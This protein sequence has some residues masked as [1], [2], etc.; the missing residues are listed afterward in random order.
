MI[1]ALN[2]KPKKNKKL[3]SLLVF[4]IFSFFPLLSQNLTYKLYWDSIN[5]LIETNY[6]TAKKKFLELKKEVQFDPTIELLFLEH[7]LRHDDIDFFK[8][9]IPDLI[10]NHGY[11]FYRVDTLRYLQNDF[12]DLVYDKGLS[13]W[14]LKSCDEL[15][16]EWIK[17]HPVQHE[18]KIRIEKLR[19]IDQ[20]RIDY[21]ILY[22]S[23]KL[24]PG[25]LKRLD[26]DIFAQLLMI[27]KENN[28]RVPNAYD[29][30]FDSGWS[31]I[32]VHNLRE[33]NM[34]EIWN[35]ILPYIE[36]AYFDKKI[37]DG[38]FRLFDDLLQRQ[39]GYQYYGF[40]EGVPIYDEE[41][42]L[43]RKAKYKFL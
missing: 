16:P 36:K 33:E 29:L 13:N 18:L 31:L 5:P 10:I 4:F 19:I 39:R 42:L 43:K 34:F 15:Y 8:S 35:L 7:S 11:K 38:L 40:L 20:T 24:A 22:D 37:G 30:G 26:Y 27:C 9:S 23:C 41:N 21:Y 3:L 25:Y 2:F 28:N 1:P 14:L 12:N 17:N 6:F 32:L